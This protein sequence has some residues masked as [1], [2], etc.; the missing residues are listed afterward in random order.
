VKKIQV[1]HSHYLKNTYIIQKE[2]VRVEPGKVILDDRSIPYDYLVINSGSAYTQPFKEAR[3]IAS[4]RANTFRESYYTLRKVKKI[5]IIGGGLVGVELAAEIVS[6]F[7]GKEVTIVHSQ[8]TLINRFPKRAIR[9]CEE[10]LKSRGV[11]IIYNERVKGHKGQLFLTDQETEIP[12][13]VAF[14]CT[15]IQPNSAFLRNEYFMD[16]ITEAGYVKANEHLQLSGNIVYPNIFVAGDVL[17]VREEKLAQAAESMG[18]VVVGNIINMER[19]KKL[20]TYVSPWSRPVLI[21]L[22]MYHGVFVYR[23]WTITGIIPALLKEAVEWKT[24]VRYR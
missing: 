19:G 12:A 10:F 7:K 21:S 8:S 20:S 16:T 13:E 2:V 3:V 11:R 5:L 9:Y 17:D 15:G 22:G 18:S 1:M 4:V 6:H 23:G 24:L 14:L